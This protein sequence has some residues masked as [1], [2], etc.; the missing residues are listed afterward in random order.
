MRRRVSHDVGTGATQC[1][2]RGG[3]IC[4]DS[5]SYDRRGPVRLSCVQ[6]VWSSVGTWKR[7]VGLAVQ[8]RACLLVPTPLK[9]SQHERCTIWLQDLITTKTTS[10]RAIIPPTTTSARR[11]RSP[12]G[13]S[14]ATATSG[15]A[16]APSASKLGRAARRSATRPLLS[17]KYPPTN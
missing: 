8:R 1:R 17:P 14:T 12:E 3:T 9:Q 4:T 2:K 13:T 16:R 5:G 15:C 11:R 7:R 10:P 6:R